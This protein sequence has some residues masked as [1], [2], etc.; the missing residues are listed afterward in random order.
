MKKTFITLAILL[1]AKTLMSV[2]LHWKAAPLEY[3]MIM[4]AAVYIDN[5]EQ[6]NELLE[7][8]VFLG[9][10]VKGSALPKLSPITNKYLYYINVYSEELTASMTFKLYNHETEEEMVL[11][12]SQVLDF[13]S[14]EDYGDDIIPYIINFT[15]PIPAVTFIGNGSWSETSNWRGSAL[16]TA[17][18]DVFIDGDATITNGSNITVKSL[19]INSG[20]SL[21][22]DNGGILTVTETVTNTDYDALII[23]EGGQIVQS[24]DNV[25]ATF[26]KTIV[27][28]SNVWGEPDKTGWQFVSSPVTKSAT[29]DFIPINDDYDLY[30]YDGTQ[31][32]QWINYKNSDDFEES[33]TSGIGYLVS[34]QTQAQASFKG[35]LNPNSFFEFAIDSYSSDN[36][37]ANFYLLGNPFTFEIDWE[38]A[39]YRR[40]EDGF[41]TLNSSTGSYIYNV[42]GLIK[43]GEGFMVCTTR[44]GAYLE[45]DNSAKS[46]REKNDYI[47]ITA[48]NVDGSDNL[49]IRFDENEEA[50]GFVKLENFND[51]IANIY[52]KSNDNNYAIFN[53]NEET[54]ELPLYFDAKEMG[55]YTLSF[56][57]K[58]NYENL[59]LIDK[60]TGEKMNL[61]IENEYSFIANS[62]DNP[63]RF[64]IKMDNNQ[65]ITDNSHFAYVSGEELIINAEGSIQIIDMMGRV[66]Y[67]ND[68]TNDNNRI[69]VRDF[70]SAAY[71]I[72]VINENGINVQKI[73]L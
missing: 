20:K 32:L 4:T 66:V 23:N 71:I 50:D 44:S 64:I 6:Q 56:D 27:V 33:F 73:I 15:T 37:L 10:V 18:D 26:K 40:I 63:E 54:T 68:V 60:M 11:D 61:L 24:N 21:T 3:D 38:L 47:N 29:A 46:R 19:A 2:E 52:V 41:A 8:G 16:P 13:V 17:D 22:I 30:K 72:R 57:I 1:F 35:N 43:V 62:N 36:V 70:N 45:Y 31:E 5:E 58:G 39:D 34:Y 9:D 25:A 48:S 67:S 28:P 53:Y 55:T 65:Q 51:K 14:E 7:L 69:D 59:Y 49:I 42:E 12:C